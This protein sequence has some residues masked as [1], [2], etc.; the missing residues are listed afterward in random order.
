[1]SVQTTSMSEARANFAEALESATNGEVVV[2]KRRG[3]PDAALVD[4]ELLEDYLASVN[5][6]I[7]KKIQKARKEK[8]TVSFDDAFQGI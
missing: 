6:R 5:P 3:K 4:A 2:I 7:I 8:A 1:M